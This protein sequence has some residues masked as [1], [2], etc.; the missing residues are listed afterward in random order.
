M[1]GYVVRLADSFT[2]DN[3]QH[4]VAKFVRED[5]VQT[6]EQWTRTGGELNMLRI[7]Q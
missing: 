2:A 6:D 7:K 1:E 5:H 4:S 3:F